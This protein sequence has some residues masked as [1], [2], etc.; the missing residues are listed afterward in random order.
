MSTTLTGTLSLSHGNR[1]IKV[2]QAEPK[3]SLLLVE[4]NDRRRLAKGLKV[5][6]SCFGATTSWIVAESQGITLT[7]VPSR[8]E[9]YPADVMAAFRRH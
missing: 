9:L 5:N 4:L 3:G 8:N 1:Q 2:G 7:L 6:L